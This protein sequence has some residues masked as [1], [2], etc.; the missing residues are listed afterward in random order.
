VRIAMIVN[1][2]RRELDVEPR[3]TLAD[4]LRGT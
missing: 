1:G 2:E 3:R 4:A